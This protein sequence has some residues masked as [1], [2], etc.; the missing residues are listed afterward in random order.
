MLVLR[1]AYAG[2]SVNVQRGIGVPPQ[3][4]GLPREPSRLL[5]R[6]PYHAG[7]PFAK[8]AAG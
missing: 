6:V 2:A 7:I 1:E 3:A 4:P 5:P 8:P